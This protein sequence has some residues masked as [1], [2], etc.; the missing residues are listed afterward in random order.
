MGSYSSQFALNAEGDLD[1]GIIIFTARDVRNNAMTLLDSF[2]V[3]DSVREHSDQTLQRFVQWFLIG[4]LQPSSH[5]RA[6]R[7]AKGL[8]AQVTSAPRS[9][10]PREVPATIAA[11]G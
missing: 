1:T 5:T 11:P 2:R 10:A 4:V 6:A 8:L 9:C 3:A 7:N